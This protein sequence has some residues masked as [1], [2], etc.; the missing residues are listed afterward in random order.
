MNKFFGHLKTINHHKKLVT[1]L[2]F[3]CG[4]YK[5]GILHDLSKYHPVEFFAGV[6]YYQGYRSPINAEKEIKGYSLGWLHHKGKNKHH[7]EYWLDN[8][9][10][11]ATDAI[12]GIVAV[13]MPKEYVV[14]M[15][16]DR[17]AASMNYQKEKYT[18]A[19]ALEYLLNGKDFVFMHPKTFELTEFLLTYLKDNGL[20][21]TIYY[22]RKN[23]LN[24]L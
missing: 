20:E 24:N 2:L 14:E 4:L 10:P 3:R 15:V 21:K 16:C 5:Q 6:K 12:H 22:M 7:W 19:S 1:I 8:A 18:D 23:I 11:N 17:I 13:E 9:G